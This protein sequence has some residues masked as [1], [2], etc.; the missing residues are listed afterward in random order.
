MERDRVAQ[1][2]IA[3]NVNRGRQRKRYCNKNND[4]K[5]AESMSVT[6]KFDII[7]TRSISQPS[8]FHS[9]ATD[10]ASQN[11]VDIWYYHTQE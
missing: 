11:R 8:V 3:E 5:L 10:E 2:V 9:F 4:I 6:E 7:F 1:R